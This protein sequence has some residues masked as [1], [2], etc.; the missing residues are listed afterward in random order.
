[1]TTLERLP[2]RHRIGDI[3][4][5]RAT[6][7]EAACEIVQFALRTNPTGAHVHLA[8]AYTI[9]LASRDLQYRSVLSDTAINFPDGKPIG[10]VSRFKGHNMPLQQV[11]GPQLFLDVM[12]E[13]IDSGVR[14]FLL[15][16][17]PEVLSLLEAKLKQL[18]PELQIA[19]TM[20]PPF[21]QPTDEELAH[22]DHTLR[23]SGAHIVW[24]GLGTPKQD[25]E[26]ERLAETIS[27]VSIAIGAAFDFVAGTQRE[28]P[29][30]MRNMGME[31]LFR[32]LTEPRRLW[33]RYLIGNFRF[34]RVAL[35]IN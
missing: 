18:F 2:I 10:W 11:R 26:V 14:H 20:S 3:N 4:F 9:A 28:A 19:G 8:N 33:R 23:E 13:G 32:L 27:A 35:S 29:N 17:T 22:R 34:L 16:S 25:H 5:V 1:M 30:Y 24:V 7:K 31:W 6:P 15:G 12:A 21:R